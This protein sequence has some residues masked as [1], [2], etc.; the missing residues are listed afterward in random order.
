MHVNPPSRVCTHFPSFLQGL[1]TQASLSK[2]C[3][4]KSHHYSGVCEP[5][6]ILLMILK[7]FSGQTRCY[8]KIT[9]ENCIKKE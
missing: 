8:L 4:D 3:S 1:G 7:R 5:F 2:I 9:E 6:N